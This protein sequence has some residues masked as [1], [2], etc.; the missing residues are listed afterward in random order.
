MQLNVTTQKVDTILALNIEAARHLY[1]QIGRW[2]GKLT[3]LC[4][5]AFPC[6]VHGGG[7]MGC[8]D[9]EG[10]LEMYLLGI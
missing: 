4:F 3:L 9:M 6:H 1:N 10:V 7:N 5:G 2:R 8:K